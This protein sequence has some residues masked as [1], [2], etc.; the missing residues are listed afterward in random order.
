MPSKNRLTA[1]PS[2]CR[3]RVVPT[4]RTGWGGGFLGPSPDVPSVGGCPPC[5]F[6]EDGSLPG[7]V[8]SA[9]VAAGWQAAVFWGV[10]P[11]KGGDGEDEGKR[12]EEER[13]EAPS[14]LFFLCEA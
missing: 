4:C 6:D 2:A 11:L 5:G 10:E 3:W 13:R 9:C 12:S 7:G 1:C 14:P 8:A